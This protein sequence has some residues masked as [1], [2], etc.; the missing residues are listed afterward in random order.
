MVKRIFIGILISLSSISALSMES[1]ELLTSVKQS[2]VF[3]CEVQKQQDTTL[4][5]FDVFIVTFEYPGA[6]GLIG[7]SD[8]ARFHEMFPPS[9]ISTFS[10]I[11]NSLSLLSSYGSVEAEARVTIKISENDCLV[12]IEIS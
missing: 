10:R 12:K 11:I 4:F 9:R 5:E 6:P 2:R 1:D 8:P 7:L 3:S